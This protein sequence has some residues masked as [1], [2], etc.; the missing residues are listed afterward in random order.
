MDSGLVVTLE[1]C[2]LSVIFISVWYHNEMPQMKT[3]QRVDMR[4]NDP[5][6]GEKRFQ[7][8]V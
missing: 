1:P 8:E 4:N 5:T 2:T 7:K 3:Q 6:E